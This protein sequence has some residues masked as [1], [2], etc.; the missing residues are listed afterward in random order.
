MDLNDAL[1]ITVVGVLVLCLVVAF[2]LD[3][4]LKKKNRKDEWL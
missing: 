1:F 3:R 2:V 4:K